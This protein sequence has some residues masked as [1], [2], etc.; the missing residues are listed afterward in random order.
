MRARSFTA[1]VPV[2]L[3]AA[4]LISC[5]DPKP[6]PPPPPPPE[7]ERCEIPLEELFAASGTSARAVRIERT[8]DLIGGQFAASAPGDFLLENDRIRVAV[9]QPGREL[10][11]IPFGGTILDADLKRPPGEPGR[12]QLGKVGMFYAFGRAIDVARVEV[13]QDGSAGGAAIVAATG[14]DALNDYVTIQA[15]IDKQNLGIQLVLDPDAALPIRA[16]TYY[17]LE[18]GADRLRVVTAFCNDGPRPV[19]FPVGEISSGGGTMDFFNPGQCRGTLG[20]ADC[21]VDPSPYFAWQ[22]DGVAYG[23]RIFKFD[24]LEE[25]APPNAL[26]YLSGSVATLAATEDLQGLL[27]WVDPEARDRPGTLVVKP[28]AQRRY[29]R[30]LV[31]ARHLGEV[32][33]AFRPPVASATATVQVTSAGQHVPGVRVAVEA[34]GSGR[35]VTILVTDA[36]GRAA[37]TLPQGRYAFTA[38]RV[39]H[40]LLSPTEVDLDANTQLE[41]PLQLGPSRRL[42]VTARDPSGAA[43]PAKVVV[44]CPGTCPVRGA[45]YARFSEREPL[46][47]DLAAVAYVPPQGTLELPLPPGQYEVMV[48]RGPEYSAWP[49]SVP[50]AGEPV[51][52]TTLDA[53]VDAVLARVVDTEGWLGAD[54]HVH[55]VNSA[56]AS[57][58]NE[59]RVLS[60]AAEGVEVLVGTDHDFVTD[61]APIVQALD[62]RPF[63]A[64]VV[65]EEISPAW[66][67]HNVF[68][69]ARDGSFN[70]GAVDWAGPDGPSLRPTQVHEEVRSRFPEAFI[71][72]NHPRGN[73]GLLTQMKVDTLTGASH[74]RPDLWRMESAPDATSTD[75]RLFGFGFDGLEL[76]NGPNPSYAVLNDWMTWLSVG[77]VRTGTGVSDSHTAFGSPAGYA[78]TYVQVDSDHPLQFDAGHFAARLRAHRA[79]ATNGPFLRVFAQKVDATGAALGAAVGVGDTVSVN[80]AAGEKL[81]ITARV[82]APEWMQFD[83]IELYTHATGREAWEGEANTAWPTGRIH[84]SRALDPAALPVVAVPGLPQTFRR[85]EVEETFEVVPTADTWFVVIV[86]SGAQA[87]DLS[88]LALRNGCNVATGACTSSAPRAFAFSNPVLVDADGSGAY[89]DFPLKPGQPLRIARP[90]PPAPP[91]WVPSV[92][93][94]EQFLRELLRHDDHD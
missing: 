79:I 21:L 32:A 90:P 4:L 18:P 75:A 8:E 27:R 22:G 81:R 48:T 65:G 64:S 93:E 62:A 11:H 51:D 67:H 68:P 71:Q 61:Y 31:V 16:T 57:P 52:L 89:D 58:R 83:R 94:A 49:D 36:N 28:G 63:M 2:L 17:V 73:H 38:G 59:D 53:A 12:D 44:R 82:Q 34:P 25:P 84:Q 1:L 54:L 86:R 76:Q 72:L 66:G 6:E 30:E 74:G 88:P 55:A 33:T 43:L 5:R 42:K 56:D 19:S 13:L 46:A 70:G 40:L 47:D 9:G 60:F 35:L 23:F 80:A 14:L 50:V 78:R 92:E 39:G 85:V 24:S 41:V 37:V 77:R 87:R 45:Q 3:G 29:A 15:A 10:A 20:E 91:R 69:I 26:V 7:I